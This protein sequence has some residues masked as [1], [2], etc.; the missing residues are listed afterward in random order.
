[1]CISNEK[2]HRVKCPEAPFDGLCAIWRGDES[3]VAVRELLL[4]QGVLPVFDCLDAASCPWVGFDFHP[5][6]LAGDPHFSSVFEDRDQ[7]RQKENS[8]IYQ[9]TQLKGKLRT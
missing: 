1:M 4:Q 8:K 6:P 2:S 5:V 3:N 9:D 7:G